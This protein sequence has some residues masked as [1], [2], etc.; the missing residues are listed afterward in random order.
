MAFKW[1]REMHFGPRA[2]RTGVR[3]ECWH[4]A[5]K[6]LGGGRPHINPGALKLPQAGK[7][8][9][10]CSRPRLPAVG[11]KNRH[12]GLPEL[13]NL[14]RI[15]NVDHVAEIS[16]LN[17]RVTGNS[18]LG[19]HPDHSAPETRPVGPCSRG[20]QGHVLSS[21]GPLHAGPAGSRGF[22]APALAPSSLLPAA[23]QCWATGHKP[24][25]VVQGPLYR[26][27]RRGPC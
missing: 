6:L 12:W 21:P 22:P 3:G 25:R 9:G 1:P 23:H 17:R 14:Q 5:R 27:A 24:T 10:Q 4:R 16:A 18:V 19:G 2:V 26:A 7:G 13:V 11:W 8:T 20:T 15:I